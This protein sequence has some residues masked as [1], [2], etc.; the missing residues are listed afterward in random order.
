MRTL[1]TPQSTL[2]AGTTFRVSARV[3]VKDAWGTFRNLSAL[4][5]TDWLTDVSWDD[6]VDEAVSQ[7]TVQLWREAYAQSLAPLKQG[8]PL[9]KDAQGN[10]GALLDMGREIKV[11]VATTAVGADPIATDWQLVFHGDVD[12]VDWG[13]GESRV[14][15]VARDLGGRLLDR[16][17]ET[18]LAYPAAGMATD[19]GGAV[20]VEALM[21]RLLDDNLGAGAV[22]L[23]VPTSP[24]WK[25]GAYKQEREPVLDALR[26]LAQ[27]FGWD[28]RYRWDAGTSSFRLKLF[29]PPRDRVVN[30][31]GNAANTA[32]D[33]T[34]GPSRYL[35]VAS[36]RLN[37]AGIRNFVQVQYL[38]KTPTGGSPVNV[39]RTAYA[40]DASSIAK[41]GRRFMEMQEDSES[42]SIDTPAEA[43]ALATSV[44]S[45]LADPRAEQE[46]EMHLFWP[47]ELGDYYL[48][49]ANGVHYDTDQVGAV[50]AVKHHLSRDQ[51]RSTITTRGRASGAY[52]DWLRREVRVAGP[53][54]AP[55]VEFK[56]EPADNA[57][58]TAGTLAVTVTSGLANVARVEFFVT[59]GPGARSALQAPDRTPSAGRYEKDVALHEQ[60]TSLIEP[61][62]TLVDGR[63]LQPGAET[64]DQGSQPA[65]VSLGAEVTE[66]G[67]VVVTVRGDS[68]TQSFRVAVR[69]DRFPTAAETRAGAL[70]VGSGVR[71]AVATLLVGSELA[72]AETAYVGALAYNDPGGA[73]KESPSM[74]TTLTR[75]SDRVPPVVSPRVGSASGA[76]AADLYAKVGSAMKETVRLHVTHEGLNAPTWSLVA[77]A[78]DLTPLWVADGT[79]LGPGSWFYPGTG[80]VAVQKL[81]AYPLARD[82]VTRVL[83][84][85][86]GRDS[87]TRSAWVPLTLSV[88]EQPWLESVDL[89]FDETSDN[90]TLRAV[91]GAFVQSATLELADNAGFSLASAVTQ[92]VTDGVAISTSRA[93]SAGER[94]RTWH[95]RVTPY[96]GPAAT[97]TAGASQR[98]SVAVP[99]G[100]GGGVEPP[101]AAIVYVSES[102][103]SF[104]LQ[105]TGTLGAGGTAPLQYRTRVSTDGAPGA[106]T[107]WAALPSSPFPQQSVGRLGSLNRVVALEVMD[108]AGRTTSDE[109]MVPARYDGLDPGSGLVDTGRPHKDGSTIFRTNVDT[110]DNVQD[111]GTYKRTTAGEK[112]GAGRASVALDAGNRLV[113]EVHSTALVGGRRASAVVDEARRGA[114]QRGPNLVANPDAE[115]GD[116]DAPP[117]YVYNWTGASRVPSTT[118]RSGGWVLEASGQ[119]IVASQELIPVDT[120][121]NYLFSASVRNA[122]GPAA[123]LFLML[124]CYDQNRRFIDSQAVYAPG[125]I[126]GT[127]ASAVSAGATSVT[128]AD[129]GAFPV[130]GNSYLAFGAALD[131]SDLPN[132]SFAAYTGR[133]GNTLTGFAPLAQGYPA[134]TRVRLHRAGGTYL[135]L[136]AAGVTAPAAWTDYSATITGAYGGESL[137]SDRFRA[138]T[139]YVA[140]GALS[141]WSGG[142]TATVQYDSWFFGELSY[143]EQAPGVVGGVEG[144]RRVD[145]LYKT[146][147][148][149][150]PVTWQRGS[151]DVLATD[152]FQKNVD[153]LDTVGDGG[154]YARTTLDQR[155]AAQEFRTGSFAVDVTRDLNGGLGYF[156]PMD[157]SAVDSRGSVA[158]L[159]GATY[160]TYRG[161]GRYGGAVSVSRPA[162]N[163][164]DTAA[165]AAGMVLASSG[166]GTGTASTVSEYAAV[167]NPLGLD[168]V[169]HSR[170]TVGPSGGMNFGMFGGLY[171]VSPGGT[172][173]ASYYL[174]ADNWAAFNGTLLYCTEYDASGAQVSGGSLVDG[175][176]TAVGG[177]WKW[178][179]GRRPVGPSTTAV[180]IGLYGY[181]SADVY[182]CGGN[183]STAIRPEPFRVGARGPGVLRL[184][185]NLR[186]DWT[187]RVLVRPLHASAD[188]WS[189]V[190]ALLT[191]YD[192]SGNWVSLAAG[193]GADLYLG[194]SAVPLAVT[195]NRPYDF[196]DPIEVVLVRGGTTVTAYVDG[197]PFLAITDGASGDISEIRLDGSAQ[198]W[199]VD[200][201]YEGLLAV[202]RAASATEVKAWANAGGAMYDALGG[203]TTRRVGTLLNGDAQLARGVSKFD[204]V[205]TVQL[206]QFA[207]AGRAAHG[208]VVPF[209]PAF[210]NIPSVLFGMGGVTYDPTLGTGPQT[211]EV[212]A[213]N[214]SP[215]GFTM[216]AV[217][218]QVATTT[219]TSRTATPSVDVATKGYTPE[220]Y[221]GTYRFN[222]EVSIVGDDLGGFTIGGSVELGFWTMAPGGGWVQRDSRT[223]DNNTG[224]FQAWNNQH[225]LVSVAGLGLGAQFQV[226]VES[227]SSNGANLSFNSVTWGEA[228]APVEHSMTPAGGTLIP[229]LALGGG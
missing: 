110:L 126:F 51:Q 55:E 168:R 137:D 188:G 199:G 174:R 228:A 44:L 215:S 82:Q 143:I 229:F 200:A 150:R 76:V 104:T 125:G 65:V 83:F 26:K 209:T 170:F 19:A 135:Y 181:A 5:G 35:D 186:G 225:V 179:N 195:A 79:E 37:R 70:L 23:W 221:D 226:T 27:Q 15:L 94:G 58:G 159:A 177:G 222:Y 62:I 213:Q 162:T 78:G 118:A 183:V 216:R 165:G 117:G 45:D 220:A 211:V 71:E 138:G 123:P 207:L 52:R 87:Q 116:V 80:L 175:V 9:N 11:E 133:S 42:S 38:D 189:T 56:L 132:Y 106:F 114:A 33:F 187:V 72:V 39:V 69:K 16:F 63:V 185:V 142:S 145:T 32:P 59:S 7:C 141:S 21:Q 18:E 115:T 31:P 139:R 204:G 111:I 67:A 101:T 48:F 154:S 193:Y 196:L 53:A 171:P 203:E 93:L 29:Q 120:A 68:D 227:D 84:Q 201:L 124:L 206:A 167:P 61:V 90:V 4:A 17:V 147:G 30:Q 190:K 108:A 191:M 54:G 131:N 198:G 113:T 146:D 140:V 223:Y 66:T 8:S 50:V 49:L 127:L 134:G 36:L 166:W 102:G 6:T 14:Q 22:A 119:I 182:F 92:A 88:K 149:L 153:T 210:Q 89:V 57:A 161:L 160:G 130:D 136:A 219:I 205:R 75:R 129:A 144:R 100:E 91:G 192:R 46:V 98:D 224:H 180:R 184:P 13:K 25:V 158:P 173:S 85:A 77:G 74:A 194:N 128:L 28:V 81:A 208:D 47:A 43:A 112:A 12:E 121:R 3:W 197:S 1:T 95:G 202:P 148:K 163:L 164:V 176:W 99:A 152:L 64:F 218:K 178:I 60:H 34:F 156:F 40:Q 2:L 172:V 212:V 155:D 24:G 10:F 20:T 214:L 151:T 169:A 105:Y 107:A 217:V 73:L 103:V 96:N 86:E 122:S 157:G 109:Y 41:Y 97:G